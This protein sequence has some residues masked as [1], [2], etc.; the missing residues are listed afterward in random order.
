MTDNQT[1]KL[2]RIY[3][4]CVNDIEDTLGLAVSESDEQRIIQSLSDAV[5]AALNV[6]NNPTVQSIDV[7]ICNLEDRVVEAS[8]AHYQAMS[9]YP[10]CQLDKL[11]QRVS[12]Y[13][14]ACSALIV[15]RAKAEQRLT[16]ESYCALPPDH[17]GRCCA[18]VTRLLTPSS[19]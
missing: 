15:A 11:N 19:N 12:D 18:V 3:R 5:D 1:L 13:R 10:I 17:E 9:N 6:V 8:L 14:S 4:S 7:E 16:H 2:S